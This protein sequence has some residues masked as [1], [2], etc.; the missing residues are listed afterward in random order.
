M[1]DMEIDLTSNEIE[2]TKSFLNKVNEVRRQN[3]AADLSFKTAVK[4]MMV[5]K[6]IYLFIFFNFY[7]L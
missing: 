6:F 3:N 2:A 7:F 5:S 1:S 4:F